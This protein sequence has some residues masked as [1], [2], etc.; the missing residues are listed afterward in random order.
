MSRFRVLIIDDE[1]E[2][3]ATLVERLSYRDI[4]AE[5]ALDGDSA[6]E[7]AAVRP[8]DVV[9]LDLKL[10]GIPGMEILQRLTNNHP[11][12][13]VILITGHGTP[14]GHESAKPEQAFDIVAKPIGLD[15]LI[16]KMEAAVK[17]HE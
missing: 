3:A 11:G 6:L 10:P 15:A 9:V 4:D 13:P 8:Y 17:E 12:L 16:E 2:L 5:Y 1:E 14:N 7:K